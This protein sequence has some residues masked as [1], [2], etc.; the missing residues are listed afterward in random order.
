M[1][2]FY[3][4]SHRC[5]WLQ[6]C[7]DTEDL[8][9]LF[10]A[11]GRR[12][13]SALEICPNSSPISFPYYLKISLAMNIC[14]SDLLNTATQKCVLLVKISSHET[15]NTFLQTDHISNSGSVHPGQR[16]LTRE[17][18]SFSPPGFQSPNGRGSGT[19]EGNSMSWKE[20]TKHT[21]DSVE[22][23]WGL[24]RAQASQLFYFRSIPT[25]ASVLGP[26]TRAQEHFCS[27]GDLPLGKNHMILKSLP[28]LVSI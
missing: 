19:L 9:L 3:P 20:S 2:I 26:W 24:H 18:I 13:Q 12:G 22:R 5:L 4:I 10:Q 25:L 8:Y 16:C 7:S 27:G 21:D 15:V 1:I 23:F 14:T 17:K 6:K 11:G 28:T